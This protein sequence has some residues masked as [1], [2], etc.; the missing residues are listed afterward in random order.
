M[1]HRKEKAQCRKFLLE[2]VLVAQY[3]QN[4]L[5]SV[6]TAPSYLS[7]KDYNP[8]PLSTAPSSM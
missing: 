3:I 1:E 7:K 4:P 2:E 6:H 8:F 5:N